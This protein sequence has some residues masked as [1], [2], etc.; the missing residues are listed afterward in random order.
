M[1]QLDSLGMVDIP[2][3]VS[4]IRQQRAGSV[5]TS[6]Q[7][8]FLYDAALTYFRISPALHRLASV[9]P[10]AFRSTNNS[11]YI[12]I[13]EQ[14]ELGQIAESS[15]DISDDPEYLIRALNQLC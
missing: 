11:G 7:F 6:D 14:E 12:T 4:I 2:A 13:G 10:D 8:N 5:Q 1:H 9:S 15:V 3:I